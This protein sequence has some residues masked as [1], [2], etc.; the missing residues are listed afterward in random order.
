MESSKIVL[1]EDLEIDRID[2]DSIFIR[3]CDPKFPKSWTKCLKLMHNGEYISSDSTIEDITAFKI[4]T[5]KELN[6]VPK[7]YGNPLLALMQLLVCREVYRQGWKP[8]WGNDCIKYCIILHG[9]NIAP[10]ISINT[11][12]MLSFQ[13]KEIRD[14]FFD[15]FRNLIEEAKELI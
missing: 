13:T 6:T 7:G 3:R 5:L 9:K 10:E 11:S 12:F 8:D 15:N 2:G 4:T 1:S 14:K